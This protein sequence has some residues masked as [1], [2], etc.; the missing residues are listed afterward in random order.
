[1]NRHTIAWIGPLAVAAV[2]LMGSVYLR[3]SS[4]QVVAEDRAD[5]ASPRRTNL[6]HAQDVSALPDRLPAM[7]DLSEWSRIPDSAPPSWRLRWESDA[8][9]AAQVLSY[10]SATSKVM[11]F[12]LTAAAG[13]A[14]I[15]E[16]SVAGGDDP[17]AQRMPDR[18][19]EAELA[20]LLRG[21]TED[22]GQEQPSRG[23]IHDILRGGTG[24]VRF[25]RGD[26]YRWV[27]R[28]DVLSLELSP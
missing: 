7:E 1:M 8:Q 14:W 11:G 24:A 13:D 25:H 27:R 23:P 18:D 10:L 9:Q 22:D 17:V 4:D 12:S 28:D 20:Q 26:T 19:V 2:I 15:I 3:F 16:A 5:T 6:D 21:R